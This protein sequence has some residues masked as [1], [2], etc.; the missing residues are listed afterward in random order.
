MTR[1]R[2]RD[3]PQGRGLMIEIETEFET[4]LPDLAGNESEV[5]EALTNLIL[6]AVDALPEGGTIGVRTRSTC[7]NVPSLV[8]GEMGTHIVV[9]VSDN[10]IGMDEATRKHCLEPF[11]STKG[12]RGTGLGLAMVYGIMERHEGEIQI[13]SQPGKGTTVRLVFP[14]RETSPGGGTGEPTLATRTRLQILCIDDEPLLRE[15]LKDLLEADG[16]RVEVTDGGQAG[17]DSFRSARERGQA[18]DVV[19]TDL[20]MPYVDGRQVAKTLKR[21]SPATPIILLTGWG[22]YM[23]E[24]GDTPAQ[25]DGVLSKPPRLRELRETITRLVPV[26]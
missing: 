15:L 18:F 3:I 17:L 20:G 14:L 26:N 1:P 24:D 13:E 2:W 12:K 22:A 21:E 23:K 11:F 7:R 16:H 5:R 9:E 19:I 6:N 8:Q 25:V 10:G 4:G